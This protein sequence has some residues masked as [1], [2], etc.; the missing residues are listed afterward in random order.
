MDA[1]SIVCIVMGCLII[2]GRGP[3]AFDP[4]RTLRWYKSFFTTNARLRAFGVSLAVG[5]TALLLAPLGE[6]LLAGLLYALGWLLAIAALLFLIMPNTFRSIIFLIFD[7]LEHSVPSAIIRVLGLLATAIGVALV[8]V[9][10][11]VV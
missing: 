7:F 5:A 9:G 6:G 4:S 3:L 2:I 11:Y 10:I 8:Y 1:L